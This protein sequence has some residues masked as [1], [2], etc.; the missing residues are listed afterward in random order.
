M[1][2]GGSPGSPHAAEM[3]IRLQMDDRLSHLAYRGSVPAH[4]PRRATAHLTWSDG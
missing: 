2:G 1:G 4:D 3:R